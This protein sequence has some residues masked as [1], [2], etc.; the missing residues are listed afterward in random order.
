[1]S[2]RFIIASLSFYHNP[3]L[4]RIEVRLFRSSK[5]NIDLGRLL[6]HSFQWSGCHDTNGTLTSEAVMYRRK[7]NGGS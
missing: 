1:M 5:E 2:Q 7:G 6:F 4:V 3:L